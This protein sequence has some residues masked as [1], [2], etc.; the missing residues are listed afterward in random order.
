MPSLTETRDRRV[1]ADAV[2]AVDRAHERV[3]RQLRIQIDAA[4][5]RGRNAAEHVGAGKI[6]F[7][8]PLQIDIASQHAFVAGVL[9]ELRR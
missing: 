7:E 8:Q 5:D 6:R 3:G 9:D 1:A 4:L 2:A